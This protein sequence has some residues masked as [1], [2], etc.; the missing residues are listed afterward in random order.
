MPT[1]LEF[2]IG[3]ISLLLADDLGN[4]HQLFLVRGEDGVRHLTPIRKFKSGSAKISSITTEQ[5]RKGFLVTDSDGNISIFHT[6]ADRHVITKNIIDKPLVHLG[7]AP[8]SNKII[9]E[10]VTGQV[11]VW[12]SR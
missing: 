11:H 12:S 2:L 6:T 3:G 10:D 8:R 1:I 7:I 9:V 4:I 5:L